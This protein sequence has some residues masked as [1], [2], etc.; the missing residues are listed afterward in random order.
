MKNNKQ[1][2]KPERSLPEARDI[3]LLNT[4]LQNSRLSARE[5]AKKMGISV[6][7]VIHR[8]KLWEKEGVIKRKREF[9]IS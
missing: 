5:I 2:L 6:V 9:D 1:V 3:L 7:T 4:L 8:M